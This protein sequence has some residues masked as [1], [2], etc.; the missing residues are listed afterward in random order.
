MR[1]DLNYLRLYMA[2]HLQFSPLSIVNHGLA[3]H[4][5]QPRMARLVQFVNDLSRRG[6]DK[7]DT[8][9]G[10]NVAIPAYMRTPI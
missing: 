4:S 1:N 9:V 2:L 8:I 10:I 3:A 5:R 7:V 6:F